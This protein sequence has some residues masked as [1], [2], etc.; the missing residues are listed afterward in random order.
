MPTNLDIGKKTVQSGARQVTTQFTNSKIFRGIQRL[1]GSHIK[2][3]N[4]FKTG[5]GRFFFLTMPKFIEHL[6]PEKTEAYRNYVE[7]GFKS[8]D[9]IQDTNMEFLDHEGGIAANKIQIAGAAKEEFDGFNIK[10]YE[11]FGSILREYHDYWI[12]GIS[13]SKSGWSTYHGLVAKDPETWYYAPE[14]HTATAIYIVTDPTGLTVEYSA[15]L[16]NI[17]P[18]AVKKDHL[19]Y[20]SGEHNNVEMDLAFSAHKEEGPDVNAKAKKILDRLKEEIVDY[21]DEV[22][23]SITDKEINSIKVVKTS[24]GSNI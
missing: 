20:N 4:F 8:F 23:E 15:Y 10:V 11:Q 3:V 21:Y 12:N 17:I 18:K 1:D 22:F 2:D 14:N 5:Y 6:L 7:R 9:G 19:N 16:T 13:D 24:T